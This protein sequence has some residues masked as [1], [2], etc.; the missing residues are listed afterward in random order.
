MRIARWSTDRAG[1]TTAC[2]LF[3][4]ASVSTAWGAELLDPGP[5]WP[6]YEVMKL[7]IP[8]DVAGGELVV[9][10]LADLDGDQLLD[11]LV[12]WRVGED[13]V[14]VAYP[15]GGREWR[16]EHHRPLMGPVILARTPAAIRHVAVSDMDWD[17]GIDVFMAIDGRS[18]L[19][20]FLLAGP[21]PAE[22]FQ[23]V[24]VAGAVTALAAHDYGRR[25]FATSPV[26]GLSTAAGPQVDLF[27]DQRAPAAQMPL[28]VPSEGPVNHILT[29]N[30]DGDAWWDLAVATDR[31][32]EILAGTDSASRSGARQISETRAR[33]TE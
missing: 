12:A 13:G 16:R 14:L 19:D 27:P 28:L 11:V 21:R 29:G 10:E 20:W 17:G 9:A 31:G 26:V 24:P 23:A 15:G 7:E 25:D 3:V 4:C 22:I 1:V 32:V 2:A 30:L 18:Q 6:K 8:D 33:F 5:P